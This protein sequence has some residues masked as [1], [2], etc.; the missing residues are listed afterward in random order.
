MSSKFYNLFGERI[1]F[2]QGNLDRYMDIVGR[3]AIEID[4]IA[5]RGYIRVGKQ[6]LLFHAAL[7][8]GF[9]HAEDGRDRL[10]E[11]DE[12]RLMAKHMR[13]QLETMTWRNRPDPITVL[14]EIVPLQEMLDEVGLARPQRL[15][16]VLGQDGSLRPAL[17]DLK[18]LGPHFTV[19][20]P[21][22]SGKTTTLY[23]WVLSLTYLLLARPGADGAN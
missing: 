21:P 5:G 11:G 20:G 16:A 9:F 18:R 2:K 4:D 3:G 13:E 14:P 23:N 7:P 8:V 17:F 10:S 1:T 15:Q 22:L 12:L 19:V 6:P